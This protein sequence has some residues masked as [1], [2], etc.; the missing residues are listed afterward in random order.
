VFEMTT[1]PQD[2]HIDN[3][4]VTVGEAN[5]PWMDAYALSMVDELQERIKSLEQENTCLNLRIQ[6]LQELCLSE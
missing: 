5:P 6:F 2:A 4:E 1:S 3:M